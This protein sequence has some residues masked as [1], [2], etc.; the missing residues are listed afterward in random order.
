[1]DDPNP[2]LVL[3]RAPG[4]H[5]GRLPAGPLHDDPRLLARESRSA[6]AALGLPP[7]AIDALRNPEPAGLT[8][9]ERWLAGDN[10]RV[11]GYGT[12]EYPI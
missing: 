3:A 10:R 6:L 11:V 4:L 12:T 2:W 8:G 5:A 1:M 9:D 7:A